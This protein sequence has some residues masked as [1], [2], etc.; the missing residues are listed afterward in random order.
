M[1][2]EHTTANTD[3]SAALLEKA[4]GDAGP[5]TKKRFAT[6]RKS[7]RSG[8]LKEPFEVL[9]HTLAF[10]AALFSIWLVDWVLGRLLGHDAKFYDRI[11]IR[12]ITD[13]AHLAVFVRFVWKLSQQIWK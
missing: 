6:L 13:T 8:V 11:P 4:T 1:T 10:L 2:D 9:A 7:A 5:R 3:G 12:Y